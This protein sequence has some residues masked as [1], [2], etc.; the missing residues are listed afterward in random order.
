MTSASIWAGVVP[1]FEDVVLVVE[2]DEALSQ[3][4]LV[5]KPLVDAQCKLS[6]CQPARQHLVRERPHGGFPPSLAVAR[7]ERETKLVEGSGQEI[8][9]VVLRLAAR[10]RGQDTE[11]R[12][13]EP[14]NE[15]LAGSA[16]D[17][18]RTGLAD[19]PENSEILQV[20]G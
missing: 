3:R 10:A 13:V 12:T 14:G 16:D 7:V 20:T 18:G 4:Q 2:L 6:R 19:T 8:G 1:V 15:C 5:A 9:H 11:R 17:I